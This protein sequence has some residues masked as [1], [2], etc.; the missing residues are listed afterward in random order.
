[1]NTL[2]SHNSANWLQGVFINKR[3]YWSSSGDA[4]DW[5]Y[6][7]VVAP[8]LAM[9]GAFRSSL[10]WAVVV[11]WISILVIQTRDCSLGGQHW[12]HAGI[13][14]FDGGH[15]HLWNFNPPIPVDVVMVKS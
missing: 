5:L 12:Y 8:W 14:L 6:V 9:I 3:S 11:W 7:S 10:S 1:M 13:V 4:V 15:P 2:F